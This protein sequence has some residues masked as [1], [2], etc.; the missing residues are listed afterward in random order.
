[1]ECVYYFYVWNNIK[2]DMPQKNGCFGAFLS[3]YF[4][5][6]VTVL[7]LATATNFDS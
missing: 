4:A 6:S 7:F 1:M 3:I 2:L 5:E